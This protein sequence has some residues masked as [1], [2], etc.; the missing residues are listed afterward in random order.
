MSTDLL[1]VYGT[2]RRASAHPMHR[3][4]HPATW[5]GPGEFQGR[6]YH[7]GNYPGMVRSDDPAD[8]VHGE[9]YRLHEPTVTLA[10]LDEYEG[11]AG[12][13]S[14]ATEYVRVVSQ[15]RL[16]GSGMARAHLYLYQRSLEGVR[17]IRSGDFLADEDRAPGG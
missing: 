15:V 10:R 6:L 17:R 4:L 3:L 5:V 11:C 2:L 16:A 8:V 7:L 14:T 9:V 12:N 13:V 1:F